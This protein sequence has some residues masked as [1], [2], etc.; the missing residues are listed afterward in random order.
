V[1]NTA[2]ITGNESAGELAGAGA[3]QPTFHLAN[4]RHLRPLDE[5]DAAELYELVERNRARLAQWMA[6]AAEQTPDQTLR[7]IHSTHSQIAQNH[8]LTAALVADDRIVG[9]VGFH[10]ID[11]PNRSASIG[12]W[13]S[14]DEQGRGTMT[15]AVRALVEHAFTHWRLNRVE[16]RADIENLRSRAVPERLGFHQEGVLRQAYRVS[17]DRYSDDAVYSMLASEWR[18]HGERS[19]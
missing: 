19:V 14:E 2:P 11:W 6:W 7:F 5:S 15:D 12:Y 4:G 3:Q 8:G 16:I 9:V 1:R 10:G 18:E 17:D 13:L